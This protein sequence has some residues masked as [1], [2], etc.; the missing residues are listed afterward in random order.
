MTRTNIDIDDDLINKAMRLHHL[1]T[2][3][4]AVHVALLRL[5]GSAPMSVDE[6]LRMRGSGWEGDLKELR[7]DRYPEWNDTSAS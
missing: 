1:S 5:V 2:K 7:D 3:R 6:Q 4:E